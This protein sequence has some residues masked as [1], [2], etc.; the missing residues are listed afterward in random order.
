VAIG[1]Q[2]KSLK[3]PSL[4]KETRLGK[5]DSVFFVVLLNYMKDMIT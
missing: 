3:F 1:D 5:L 2:R 4:A